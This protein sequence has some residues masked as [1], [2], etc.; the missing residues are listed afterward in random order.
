MGIQHGEVPYLKKPVSRL[1]YGTAT[2]LMEDRNSCFDL[3]DSV[4]AQG[5]N[6]FDTAVQYG[7]M[8]ANFG[9]WVADRKLRDKIVII[10]K[11]GH[12]NKWRNRLTPYDILS[13]LHDSLAK[14]HTDHIDI[15]LLHRDDPDVPVGPI[16]QV[17]NDLHNAGKIGAFGGSNWTSARIEEAN[18]Y[19]LAHNLIPFTV[20]SPFY[21]LAEQVNDPWGGGCVSISG[22]SGKTERDWYLKNK[23]PVFAYSSLA[24]GLLAGKIKSSQREK[25][26]EIFDTPTVSGYCCEA[27]FDR[28]ARV[29]TLAA[30]KGCGVAQI[31]LAWLMQQELHP[32]ALVSGSAEHMRK[33]I[34]ALDIPLTQNELDFLAG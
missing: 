1:I 17:L 15:Y 7:E 9:G 21:S 8:E 14:L 19:A 13:D 3:L 28:L 34:E 27:N 10:S 29:E 5:V 24:R 6:T 32:F 33:N 18:G 30:Q 12:P 25:A 20:S 26:A 4:Y 22:P 11:G 31:A 2:S 23:M 16:V